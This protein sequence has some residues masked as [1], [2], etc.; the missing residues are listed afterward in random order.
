MRTIVTLLVPLTAVFV[1]CATT[2]LDWPWL[3][4]VPGVLASLRVPAVPPSALSAEAQKR[5]HNKYL[6]RVRVFVE[7]PL[8]LLLKG[9][10]CAIAHRQLAIQLFYVLQV[11]VQAAAAAETKQRVEPQNNRQ[12]IELYKRKLTL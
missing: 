1:L 7:Q 2:K 9:S 8:Q 4:Y 11:R 12:L 5:L 3:P 10:C 6:F